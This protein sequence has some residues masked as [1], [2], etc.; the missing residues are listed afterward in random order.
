MAVG[1]MAELWT[2]FWIR[3]TGMGQ[4]VVQHHNRYTMMMMMMMMMMM[5]VVMMMMM[6]FYF[7]NKHRSTPSPTR[8]LSF[9]IHFRS[10]VLRDKANFAAR[11]LPHKVSCFD[12]LC[13]WYSWHITT[14][15]ISKTEYSARFIGT[16]DLF[17]SF[18][19]EIYTP[20][21]RGVWLIL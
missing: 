9:H 14:E 5:V 6:I 10:V 13:Y 18:C 15:N 2:D 8:C 4:Q 17:R 19:C 12:C 11:L 21:L 7:R 3:E 16:F 1:I 20:S